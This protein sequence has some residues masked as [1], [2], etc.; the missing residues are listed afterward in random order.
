ME[1]FNLSC[2]LRA[3]AFAEAGALG[4]GEFISANF[5]LPRSGEDEMEFV[6]E[7]ALKQDIPFAG[8]QPDAP[9]WG[10]INVEVISFAHF[11]SEH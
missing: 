2:E 7:L 5:V 3:E 10:A 11:V 4:F 8:V 6:V 9:A 1:N